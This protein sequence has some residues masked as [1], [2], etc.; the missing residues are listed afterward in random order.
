M[1]ELLAAGKPLHI[2]REEPMTE[3][4]RK[5]LWASG[6]QQMALY[7]V[8]GVCLA[9]VPFL[10]SEAELSWNS[11]YLISAGVAIAYASLLVAVYM[12]MRRAYSGTKQVIT[13]FITEKSREKMKQGYAHFITVGKDELIRVDTG[14]Y[15]RYALG[16]TVECHVFRRW[17]IVVF[18]HKPVSFELPRE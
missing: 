13:G 11:K 2:S 4:E 16:D 5:E 8:L 1:Q 14:S 9:G 6:Y 15:H 17:G 12:K 18:S 3:E 10:G 7:I